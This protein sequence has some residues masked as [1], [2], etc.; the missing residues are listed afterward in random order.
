MLAEATLPP[1]IFIAKWRR[2]MLN[3][4]VSLR[5]SLAAKAHY[6]FAKALSPPHAS[7]QQL[8]HFTNGR[9]IHALRK[10]KHSVS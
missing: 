10:S 8:S 2:R 5:V 3:L 9:K 7:Q 1:A 6:E 4:V